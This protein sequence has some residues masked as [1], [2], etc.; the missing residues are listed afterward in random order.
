MWS[1][2]QWCNIIWAEGRLMCGSGL[3]SYHCMIDL[4]AGLLLRDP[5]QDIWSM[6]I[7]SD[8]LTLNSAL[9]LD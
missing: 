3:L 6:I 5:S 2:N 1:C 9:H 7:H 4:A 8:T